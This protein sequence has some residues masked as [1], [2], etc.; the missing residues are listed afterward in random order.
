[1]EAATPCK[2][3]DPSQ[4]SFQAT[5]AGL[6]APNK[7]PKTKHACAV[8]SH[9]STRQRMEP[10]LQRGHEDHIAARGENSMNHYSL[11]HELIPMQ[12]AMRIPDAKAAVEK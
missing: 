4:P 8:E 2:K 11:A 5:G 12:K 1:M 6:G 10:T 3:K 9:E 7:V